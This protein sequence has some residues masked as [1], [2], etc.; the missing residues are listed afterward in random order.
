MIRNAI[1]RTTGTTRH[2]NAESKAT[3]MRAAAV[4]RLAAEPSDNC[5]GAELGDEMDMTAMELKVSVQVIRVSTGDRP[6]SLS[7]LEFHSLS[8]VEAP[9][10]RP[11]SSPFSV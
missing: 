11:V 4:I 10:S 8:F 7:I 1:E 6:T 5:Q 9:V 2:A 3:A